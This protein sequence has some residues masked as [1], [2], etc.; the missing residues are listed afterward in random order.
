MT[1]RHYKHNKKLLQYKNK[2]RSISAMNKN[3]KKEYRITS[4]V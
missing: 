4:Y 1:M 3:E 2:I